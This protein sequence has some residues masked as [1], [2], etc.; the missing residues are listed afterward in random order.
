MTDHSTDRSRSPAVQPDHDTQS[1]AAGDRAAVPDDSHPLL[2]VENLETHFPITRG[3]LRREV[4]RVRAVDGV[5]FEIRDGEAFGL[6][7][8]SGSGKTTTALSALRLEEPT[9]GE[10]RFDGDSIMSLSGADLRAFRRRAQL[11]VQDPNEAFNP[12]LTIG[13]AVAEPLA[14][15]G[16][17]DADRRQA[18]VT[19]LLERV[20]LSADDVDR[21]PHEFSGGE[22][23]R[24]AIA[25]ALVLNPDLI[26]ADEPTSA[27]DGRVQSDVLALLD[28]LR[29]EFDIAV[30]FISH[31]IDVVRRFCDRIGVMYLGEIV[32]Q[33][34][35]D[36]VLEAPAH[37]Y[38]RT[39]LGSVP[40]LDPSDR[41]LV[42]P[43][44]DT[45]P[46]PSDPPSGCR[47]HT[48]CPEL[49]PPEDVDLD[50]ELWQTIAAFRFTLQADE[51]PAAIEPDAGTTAV[52]EATVRETFGLP[53]DIPDER[54]DRGVDDAVDAIVRGDLEVARDRLAEA[55]PTVC[56]R[57]TPSDG[58]D[59]ERPVRCHRYDPSVD[60]EPLSWP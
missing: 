3:L 55:I 19:D 28:E 13:Q 24:I 41:E 38:T 48:R 56:E 46:D 21:Y 25:R 8:E 52:D 33:G 30:L 53:S 11:V 60:A 22:K 50:R 4:G 5:S 36:E 47:F 10:I 7:G 58:T 37:P 23:Q 27:L 18:I 29:R 26:V 59:C 54:V 35:T 15:H 20:G 45:I 6:V 49:I 43:L 32:E 34:P 42:R 2:E 39:L 40:S 44:T 16:M 51:L 9:G 31:D 12:R 57:S 14:L 1:D 17:D